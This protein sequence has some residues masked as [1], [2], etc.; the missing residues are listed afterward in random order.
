MQLVRATSAPVPVISL[1]KMIVEI[2]MF[3]LAA[4]NPAIPADPKVP[5]WRGIS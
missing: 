1:I 5:G 4:K 2:G 3:A